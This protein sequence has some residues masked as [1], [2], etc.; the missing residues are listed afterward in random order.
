MI[1]NIYVRYS[2]EHEDYIRINSPDLS[3]E[4]EDENDGHIDIDAADIILNQFLIED[5]YREPAECPI[6]FECIQKDK[7]IKTNCHHEFCSNCIY[8][9]LL[10]SI[11]DSKPKMQ[12]PMCR[13]EI[14]DVNVYFIKREL[15]Y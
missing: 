4:I 9:V 10:Q 8:G 2:I 14:N 1:Y 15:A 12:C 5:E 13:C 6:C 11:K 3:Q 7:Y